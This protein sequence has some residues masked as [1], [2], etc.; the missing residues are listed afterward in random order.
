MGEGS[1]QGV[2]VGKSVGQEGAEVAAGAPGVGE[3]VEGSLVGE[4]P[5]GPG[6]GGGRW[7]LHPGRSVGQGAVQLQRPGDSQ[8]EALARQGAGP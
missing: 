1:A 8:R 2:Q 3:Q 5:S 4:E 6:R 7:F